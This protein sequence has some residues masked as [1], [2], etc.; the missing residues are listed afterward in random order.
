MR[1]RAETDVVICGGGTAGAIAAIASALGQAVCMPTGHAA[2]T[3]DALARQAGLSPREV[4]VG[5]V[6]RTLLAQGAIL[7]YPDGL[8]AETS[9]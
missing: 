8:T 1:T 3:A 6:Q 2:G 5:T 4:D 7:F 9:R